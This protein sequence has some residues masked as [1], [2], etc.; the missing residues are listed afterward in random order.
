MEFIHTDIETTEVDIKLEKDDFTKTENI[1]DAE[2]F[3]SDLPI[4]LVNNKNRGINFKVEDDNYCDI[5]NDYDD[6]DID[7]EPKKKKSKT[8]DS[9]KR[10]K[11]KKKRVTRSSSRKQLSIKNEMIDI[12]EKITTKKKLFTS[13]Q[14]K[15]KERILKLLQSGEF[16]D[17]GDNVTMNEELFLKMF[18]KCDK[19][20]LYSML[21]VKPGKCNAK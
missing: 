12:S 13:N 19:S 15:L 3:K 6:S 10:N 17:L 14:V 20:G 7:Y 1:I 18:E 21:L 11:T 5:F 8:M 2:E 9:F 16:Q 4:D